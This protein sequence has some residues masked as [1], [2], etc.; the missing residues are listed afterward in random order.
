MDQGRTCRQE[1]GAQGASTLG[2]CSP[3]PFCESAFPS[4]AI[5]ARFLAWLGH[6]NLLLESCP[7]LGTA[8]VPDGAAAIWKC[9]RACG[10]I[11]GD[12]YLPVIWGICTVAG[13]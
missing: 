11:L 13:L 10:A 2:M 4:C 7:A 12:F 6:G 5:L 1:Q 8:K 9:A 3:Y